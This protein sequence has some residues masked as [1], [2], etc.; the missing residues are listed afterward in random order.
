MSHLLYT[1][2][3]RTF[4]FPEKKER[5]KAMFPIS[6]PHHLSQRD[7][8]SCRYSCHSYAHTVQYFPNG[9]PY[10]SQTPVRPQNMYDPSEY[11]YN[12]LLARTGHYQ[13]AEYQISSNK[14]ASPATNNWKKGSSGKNGQ[15]RRC[16][17]TANFQW[18]SIKRERK[19]ST[20]VE[21]GKVE[22]FFN[23]ELFFG[24]LPNGLF[25]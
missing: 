12:Q 11:D 13:A 14:Y 25:R 9:L 3:A 10:E 6:N 20:S 24:T 2:F 5:L 4:I 23:F 16:W 1:T 18:M 21:S 8:S 15:Q 19:S 17:N 7:L 22:F